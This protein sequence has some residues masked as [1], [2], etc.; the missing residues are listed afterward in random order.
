MKINGLEIE[1]LNISEA[2][3]LYKEI[4][5]EKVY[6]V[7]NFIPNRILDV[8][9]YIGL[10][11]IWFA[12]QYPSAEI[13]ALEPNKQAFNALVKNTS[14]FSNVSSLNKALGIINGDQKFYIDN[15]WMSVSS[16]YP[17]SWLGNR[18]SYSTMVNVV[19]LHALIEQFGAFD[20]VKLDVEGLEM[21][22]LKRNIPIFQAVSVLIAEFHETKNRK[23]ENFLKLLRKA[24]FNK[25]SVAEDNDSRYRDKEFNLYMIY[26]TK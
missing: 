5:K 21:K 6:E 1:V 12:E 10:S 13:L 15:E 24:N 4:F 23:L 18:E 8:G 22:I 3:R 26:A 17:G 7:L 20:L 14:Y 9:A 25:V 19:T 16:F 2:R 11:T